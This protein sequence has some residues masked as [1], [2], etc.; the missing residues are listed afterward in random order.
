MLPVVASKSF[1][2]NE[3]APLVLPSA[4][5]FWIPSEP[6]EPICMSEPVSGEVAESVEVATLETP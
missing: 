4:A 2:V 5:A 6:P 3:A 1:A